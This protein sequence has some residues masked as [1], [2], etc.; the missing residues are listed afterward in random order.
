MYRLYI[1][2]SGDHTYS[3]LENT[4]R[5]YL[6]L[7]GCAFSL[8]HYQ[9]LFHPRLD[10]LKEQFFPHD[11]DEPVILHRE[12]I[13]NA[14]GVFRRLLDC[15]LRATF[16]AELFRLIE[17]SEFRIIAVVI[18]KKA[19][20]ERYREAAWH[21]YHYCLTALMER[22][23]GL[24]HL[25][26]EKG[27]VM[28]EGRGKTEDLQL[29]REYERIYTDGAY[30]RS[31]PW[32]REVLTSHE[33]KVKPKSKN[34][35]G[36]QLADLIAHPVKQEMLL[37]KGRLPAGADNFGRALCRALASKFN[38]QVYTGQVWGYGKKMFD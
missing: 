10:A 11:P 7:L 19:H 27:D 4:D 5:R 24:L 37:E 28:A 25:L 8:Q 36:L 32:F 23:C 20:V 33:I 35:A 16:D 18:D 12:D 2:E 29:K 22:Y 9:E 1:D 31:A 14:R 21:P 15:E 30:H 17:S 6:C 38:R 34:V 26:R 3:Q 13:I